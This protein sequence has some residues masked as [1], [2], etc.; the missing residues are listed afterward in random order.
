MPAFRLRRLVLTGFRSW[1]SL[2]LELPARITVVAG[3]NGAG[4]TN[5]L[6]AISLL[7]PG[8][9]LRGAKPADLGRIGP[10]GQS[11]WAI[12]AD[13]EGPEGEARIATGTPPGGDPSARR[14]VLL[15]GVALRAQ[16]ELARF[17][18]AAWLTPQ[19]DRLFEDSASDRRRFLDRLVYA[20][21]PSHAREVAAHDAAMAGRNRLLAEGCGDPAWLAALEDSIARHAVAVVAA[22][23]ALVARLNA[24]LEAGVVGG[25]PAAR[26]VLDC[27]IAAALEEGPALAAEEALRDSLAADRVRDAASGGAARGAHRTDFR[28]IHAESRLPADLCSTGERKALLVSTLLAHAALVGAARGAAPV[29][30]LDEVAVHLDAGRRA[31]LFAALAALPSQAILTGTDLEPFAPLRDVAAAFL[32]GGGGLAAAPGFAPADALASD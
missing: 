28:M 32:A 20:L 29:L 9:G 6:E 2:S 17:M 5:L 25:F 27:P 21:E 13:I 31:A 30:L 14:V 16:S 18:A 12:S 26:L 10:E 11:A 15:D 8:R 4:K 1:A 22:R 24:A 3:P 19:M 7:A 23:R